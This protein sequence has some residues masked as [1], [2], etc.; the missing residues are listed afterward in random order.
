MADLHCARRITRI[1]PTISCRTPVR[2]SEG[3]AIEDV[4]IGR[5][6]ITARYLVT[7]QPLKLRHRTATAETAQVTLDF[8]PAYPGATAYRIPIAVAL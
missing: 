3:D 4:P 5:Y 7:G 8:E 1:R 6:A 2:R